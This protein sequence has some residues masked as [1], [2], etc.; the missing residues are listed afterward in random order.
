MKS[1][2]ITFN[3]L[4]FAMLIQAGVRHLPYPDDD[5]TQILALL[6]PAAAILALVPWRTIGK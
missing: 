2:A 3:I 4:L 1:I 5:F 6:A